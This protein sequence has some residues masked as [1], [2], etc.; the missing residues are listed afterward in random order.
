MAAVLDAPDTTAV[1]LTQFEADLASH[2]WTTPEDV[3]PMHGGFV[4]G[5]AGEWRSYCEGDEG[6]DLTV[7]VRARDGGSSEV[8]LRLTWDTIHRPHRYPRAMLPGADLLPRLHP[9]LGELIRIRAAAAGGKL[10]AT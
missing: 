8:Q 3:R 4:A 6:P 1:V 2:G 7:T 5:E 9:R 10:A